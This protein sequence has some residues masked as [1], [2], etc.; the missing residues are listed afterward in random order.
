MAHQPQDTDGD[1]SRSCT[2]A[3]LRSTGVTHNIGAPYPSITPWSLP[4]LTLKSGDHLQ[5]PGS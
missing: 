5:I 1:S 4:K 3:V 2:V